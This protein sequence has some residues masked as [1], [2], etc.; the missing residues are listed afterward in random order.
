LK[1]KCVAHLNITQNIQNSASSRHKLHYWIGDDL[2]ILYVS[3]Y[4]MIRKTKRLI[5]PIT[6]GTD[7]NHKVM[8]WCHVNSVTSRHKL[9]T[10]R[11]GIGMGVPRISSRCTH[12]I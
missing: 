1:F 4:N 10:M 8:L 9:V 6:F 3:K 2:L 11:N 5:I 7:V 12:K